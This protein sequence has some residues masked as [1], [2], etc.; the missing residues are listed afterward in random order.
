[1]TA[2]AQVIVELTLGH[3][4]PRCLHVI[5]HFGVADALGDRPA[6]AHDLAARTG[7]N[8]DAL[9]RMLRLLA[10]HGV[11]AHCTEGY[12]HTAASRLLRSDH[13][14]SMRAYARMIGMP[15]I[16]DGV[17]QL[18]HATRTGR[19]VSDSAAKFAYLA[20]HAD[21]ASLFNA[22]MVA[23][24]AGVVP[25][26]LDS[27][28]F[29]QFR[30]IADIGGGRA[31]LLRAI[32]ERVPAASGTLFDLP[33]VIAD[34]AEIASPRLTPVAGDFFVDSL[35]VAD[36]YILMEVIH[37]WGD[38]ES[39]TILAAV[40]RAAP[41]HARLVIVE[42]LVSETPGQQFGKTLDIVMLAVTG[43]RERTPSEYAALLAAAGFRFERV[44][45]TA[46]AYSV[47]EAVVA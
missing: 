9:G 37:D 47:L 19:P 35:P 7:I 14:Q 45:P 39:T 46:S 40:R 36:C 13:P 18:E 10:A 16:W 11:F 12:T 4:A 26:V 1:M 25:A 28:D 42:T 34:A 24:S 3:L 20:E 5:A 31:H 23:K 2:P 30:R 6:S 33:Y 29:S 32:L 21:E 41:K 38:A 17:T 8:P 15:L 22:A 43:G 44:V 27:Y